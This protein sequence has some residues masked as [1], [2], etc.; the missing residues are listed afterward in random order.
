MGPSWGSRFDAAGQ[1][2]NTLGTTL[3]SA[4]ESGVNDVITSDLSALVQDFTFLQQY[5]LEQNGPS[6]NG[7]L[8]QAKKDS[9]ILG[10]HCHTSS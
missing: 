5:A 1:A 9:Q 4:Y 7:V 2:E 6:Y 8:A 10:T 3:E